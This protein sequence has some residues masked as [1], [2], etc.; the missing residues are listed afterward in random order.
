MRIQYDILLVC[1]IAVPFTQSG[2]ERV[3]SKL[4]STLVS[5][6]LWNQWLIPATLLTMDYEL[7]TKYSHCR[8]D[9]VTVTVVVSY[10]TLHVHDDH[11]VG[12]AAHHKVLGVLGHGDHAV[13]A[14][15]EL[16]DVPSDLNVW[17]H[18]VVFTFHIWNH[19]RG[20]LLRCTLLLAAPAPAQVRYL[21]RAVR[22]GAHD[23]MVVLGEP[24]L[25][26]KRGVASELLQG[27][28]GLQ[29]VDPANNMVGRWR[30]SFNT[31]IMAFHFQ[32]YYYV[33]TFTKVKNVIQGS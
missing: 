11:G 22:R 33:L 6:V 4:T 24:R 16:D 18:S 1:L 7:L 21:H 17:A 30:E 12:A 5:V 15:S 10:L 26:H 3:K 19:E 25:V 31:N 2:T 9:G 32:Y 27:L 13:T 28:A 29:P 14:M 20:P 8:I 23:E